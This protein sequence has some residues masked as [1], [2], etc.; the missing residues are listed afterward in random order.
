MMEYIV[1]PDRNDSFSRII[2]GRQEYLLRFLYNGS[3]DYWS[4]G[5]YSTGKQ[6]LLQQRKIVPLSPL[7]HFDISEKMPQG[8]FGCL[9]KLKYVGRNDFRDGRAEFVFIPWEDLEVW[10]KENGIIR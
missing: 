5:V 2:L 1:V 3:Y 6:P 8:I 7:T 4:F 9:T 10:K